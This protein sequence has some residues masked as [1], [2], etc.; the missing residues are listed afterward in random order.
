MTTIC[1]DK[2]CALLSLNDRLHW[3]EKGRRSRA[4]RTATA[5]A[6]I[7]VLGPPSKRRQPR[8]LVT[9]TLPVRS[10]KTKRDAHNYFAT[11]K[12][13]IDGLVD[14]GC[15]PD[16]DGEWVVTAEPRFRVN[17]AVTVEL[18]PMPAEVAA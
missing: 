11:V 14:A 3:A 4:W 9:V 15:W 8:S 10:N 12:P 2:P 17:G 16:D 5:A 6:A 18:T 13:I 1:F 7:Q